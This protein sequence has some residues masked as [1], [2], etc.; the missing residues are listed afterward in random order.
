MFA[1]KQQPLAEGTFRQFKAGKWREIE[2]VITPERFLSLVWP[3]RT[4][5]RLSAWGT[6]EDELGDTRLAL[7]HAFTEFCGPG[8]RPALVERC[9]G[10]I[11]LELRQGQH[12]PPLEEPPY[13]PVAPLRLLERMERFSVEE[14]RFQATGCFHRAAVYDPT[15][16]LVLHQVED[17][18]RHNCLDRICG[19]LLEQ[20]LDPRKLI[21]MVSAR[22][23]STLV[24]KVTRA[25]FSLLITRS[26]VTT[27]ALAQCKDAGVSLVGFARDGR[28]TVFHDSRGLVLDPANAPNAHGAAG[29]AER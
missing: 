1:T 28:F 10:E 19:Y 4:P 29:A 23:T 8:E 17:I 14:G 13:A 26:A 3:G 21:C 27:A 9:P 25:G 5:V 15:M 12:R 16:D 2:D 7:G 6:V 20:G 18:G 24:R 22:A 11:R